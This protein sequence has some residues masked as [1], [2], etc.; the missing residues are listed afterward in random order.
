MTA[1]DEV[2][3]ILSIVVG[4]AAIGSSFLVKRFY[5]GRILGGPTS[6]KGR[7]I[8]RWQG[9]LICLVARILFLLFGLRYFLLH[10]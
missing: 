6:A 7:P 5:S 10:Q 3:A 2:E 1:I 4:C 9:R 8:P